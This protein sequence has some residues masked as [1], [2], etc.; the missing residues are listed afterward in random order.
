MYVRTMY[1]PMYYNKN[2]FIFKMKE[3]EGLYYI[4]TDKIFKKDQD[5]DT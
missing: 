4:K 2:L 5:D 1:V 3:H